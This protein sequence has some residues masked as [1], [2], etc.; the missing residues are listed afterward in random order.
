MLAMKSAS[1]RARMV[2]FAPGPGVGVENE[3]RE[4]R[5]VREVVVA[6]E[7]R[8]ERSEAVV[9]VDWTEARAEGGRE[10]EFEGAGAGAGADMGGGRG[11]G[12][13]RVFVREVDELLAD[14]E[15]IGAGEATREVVEGKED[16]EVR[17]FGEP[18]GWGEGR[19]GS[20]G[21]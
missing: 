17:L 18:R 3:A 4:D 2:C 20:L 12:K 1:Y 6:C 7:K 15:S 21:G 5:E 14:S 9:V 10:R 8:E 13:R 11:G 16:C 19:C